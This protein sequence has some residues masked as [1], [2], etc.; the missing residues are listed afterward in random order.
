MGADPDA[1]RSARG[2]TRARR[3]RRGVRTGSHQPDASRA[4]GRERGR[5][6]P[7]R[8][9]GLLVQGDRRDR[10]RLIDRRAE[11]D[12]ACPDGVQGCVR[13]NPR[14][15]FVIGVVGN[16]AP[17]LAT[18]VLSAFVD[19]ETTVVESEAVRR[20]IAVCASC[21]EVLEELRGVDEVLASPATLSCDS[22]LPLL[23]AE[24][25]GELESD[26]APLVR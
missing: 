15:S 20:H 5:A 10:G 11:P 7:A 9:R 12:R 1:H 18:E 21:A 14:R 23:S 4:A 22:V 13:D 17:H 6:A 8:A 24:L 25:D 26:I 2:A 19:G 16:S 3:A